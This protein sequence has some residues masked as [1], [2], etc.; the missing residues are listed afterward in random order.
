MA[1]Q[2][3]MIEDYLLFSLWFSSEVEVAGKGILEALASFLV[4]RIISSGSLEV[5]GYRFVLFSLVLYLVCMR[6]NISGCTVQ[7]YLSTILHSE[8]PPLVFPSIW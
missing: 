7:K 5:T 3:S 6:D 4:L 1:E 2:V 8:V